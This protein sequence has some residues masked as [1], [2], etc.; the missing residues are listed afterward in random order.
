MY[1]F[2]C[3]C[4]I[5]ITVSFAQYHHCF[6]V[7]VEKSGFVAFQNY[8]THR[9]LYR[10]QF[11]FALNVHHYIDFIM[12]TM[13]SQITSLTIVYS[14]VYSDADQRKHQ[15]SASLAFVWGI[16][17]TGE[18]PAQRA[19][20]A[21]NVSIWWRHHDNIWVQ[22]LPIPY[23]WNLQSPEWTLFFQKRRIPLQSLRALNLRT[24]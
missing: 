2:A 5:P 4:C 12:I 7:N 23:F 22:L 24:F 1:I 6:I 19:S 21:E 10:D 8:Q 11:Q 16:H 13:A 18:F 17:R 14:T 9:L 20:N 15:S 3:I